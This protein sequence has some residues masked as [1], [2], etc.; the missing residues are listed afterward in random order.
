M[1]LTGFARTG[2]APDRPPAPRPAQSDM[3]VGAFYFP[4]WSAPQRWY[5]IKANE[6]AQHPLLGYYPEGDPDVAD[7]HIKWALEHG[8]SFFAFDYYLFGGAERL[9]AALAD[10]FLRAAYLDRFRFCLNWCNHAPPETQTREEF[11]QFADLVVDKY[12]R[13]PSYLTIRDRPVVMILSGFSFVKT[14]GVEGARQAFACLNERCRAAGLADA[15]LVFCEGHILREQDIKDSL[16]AG[17]EALCLYNYPYAGTSVTGPGQHA[18]ASY[19]H[20]VAQGETGWRHWR[21]LADGRFWP[22]VM[23]GWDRRPWTKDRDLLRTGSTPDLFERSLLAA[24][25]HVNEDRV[26]IV[27]AWNEWGEGSVLEPSVERRFDYLDRVRKV[28]CPGAPDDPDL[29]DYAAGLPAWDV[30]L[31]ETTLWAFDFDLQGWTGSSVR[32]LAVADGALVATS[33]N[34]DPQLHAPPSYVRAESRRRLLLRLRL[35][36]AQEPS[37]HVT[38]QVFWTTVQRAMCEETS[39]YFDPLLDGR[40]HDYSVDLGASPAWAGLVDGLRL[41]PVNLADV[42]TELDRVELVP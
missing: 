40:W 37:G 34:Q 27:E 10:G 33:V 3:L 42:K 30:A 16:G 7:W 12:L 5:C 21:S 38:G 9:E 36:P 11:D 14:L 28:F 8:V 6:E 1:Q 31:P 29:H 41:D 23:P 32:D 15:Y 17:A 24:R 25:Q 20:L 18:E 39:V 2:A 26:V 4:G 19:E 13:H 35:T 22:T